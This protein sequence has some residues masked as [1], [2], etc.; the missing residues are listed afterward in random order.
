MKPRD[1]GERVRPR[2]TQAATRVRALLVLTMVAASACAHDVRATYPRPHGP[3]PGGPVG[4]L[5]L[6]FSGDADDVAVTVDG[7]LVVRDAH[8][9]HIIIE[10]VP[11]GAVDV[12]VATGPGEKAMEVWIH[13]GQTTTVPLG[14]GGGGTVLGPLTSAFVSLA[15]VVLYALLN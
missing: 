5:E 8:T 12:V 6:L 15:S 3:T 4:R 11:A 7:Q 13:E 10:Q 14:G 2:P 9:G 1:D